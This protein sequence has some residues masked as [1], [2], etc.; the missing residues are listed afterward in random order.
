MRKGGDEM[1]LYRR[2]LRLLIGLTLLMLFFSYPQNA[3]S[4]ISWKRWAKGKPIQATLM[5]LEAQVRPDEVV[6][7]RV[8]EIKDEDY[9]VTYVQDEKDESKLPVELA[10]KR[11]ED[12]CTLEWYQKGGEFK[13]PVQGTIMEWR[14][15]REAGTY[16]VGVIIDDLALIRA[17]DRGNRDD[18]TLRLVATVTVSGVA[19]LT[20]WLIIVAVVVLLV[21]FIIWLT[22]YRLK[23]ARREEA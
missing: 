15:P 17:P 14:A 4:Q 2:A 3:F 6:V 10:G 19:G 23:R 8:S 16:E 11:E 13:T 5:P 1:A 22:F 7:F 12:I 21:A 9:Y 18:E 20:L